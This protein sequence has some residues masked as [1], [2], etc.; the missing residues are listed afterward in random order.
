MKALVAILAVCAIVG[1]MFY[2]RPQHA[3]RPRVKVTLD[4]SV[5]PA[6]QVPFVMSQAGA[7]KLKYEVG[8]QAGM[9]PAFWNR[10]S[11]R[12]LTNQSLLEVQAGAETKEEAQRFVDAYMERLQ[13]WCTNRAQ[14][15]A[16]GQSIK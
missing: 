6:E 9:K 3:E 8:T 2:F 14:I 1:A 12:Y 10:L 7:V 4:I 11:I 13:A 15:T 16:A 5:S